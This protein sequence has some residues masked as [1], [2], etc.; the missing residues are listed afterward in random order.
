MW[1]PTTSC[2]L[3]LEVYI[4]ES[5]CSWFTSWRRQTETLFYW[6]SASA[7]L[8]LN[9]K[10]NMTDTH[11]T[12]IDL[13]ALLWQ[14]CLHRTYSSERQYEYNLSKQLTSSTAYGIFIRPREK[15]ITVFSFIHQFTC[16]TIILYFPL[17]I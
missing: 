10:L 9:S 8:S 3:K 1:Q 13:R 6:H 17:D 15:K 11:P 16:K 12:A 7:K 5:L 2:Y 14:I 4:L